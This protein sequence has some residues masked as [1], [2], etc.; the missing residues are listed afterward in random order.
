MKIMKKLCLLLIVIPTFAAAGVDYQRC[1]TNNEQSDCKK[2]KLKQEHGI[3]S[4]SDNNISINVQLDKPLNF[5]KIKIE[6]KKLQVNTITSLSEKWQ[7]IHHHLTEID[8]GK[9]V[10]VIIDDGFL[11]LTSTK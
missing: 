6:S 7:L 3:W 11:R 1:F 9:Q 10:N 5:Y 2:Y 8:D 4:Y